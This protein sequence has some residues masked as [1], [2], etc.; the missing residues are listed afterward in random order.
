MKEETPN[1]IKRCLK[2]CGS[3]TIDYAAPLANFDEEFH[4]L[5]S[6]IQVNGSINE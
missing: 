2:K 6:K 4:M 5:V 1:A 3:P